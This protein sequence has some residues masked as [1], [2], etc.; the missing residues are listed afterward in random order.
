[1]PG[2][3]AIVL[4]A[5]GRHGPDAGEYGK[6]ISVTLVPRSE[7]ERPELRGPTHGRLS[8]PKVYCEGFYR[9]STGLRSSPGE[10][11]CEY[12]GGTREYGCRTRA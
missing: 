7:C 2:A 12:L 9:G 1:M 8:P 10:T 5:E 6:K 11:S 3:P 4:L